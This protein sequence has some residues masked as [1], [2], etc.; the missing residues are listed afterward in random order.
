MHKQPYKVHVMKERWSYVMKCACC[1][2][3]RGSGGIKHENYLVREIQEVQEFH[4]KHCNNAMCFISIDYHAAEINNTWVEALT[5]D[6]TTSATWSTVSGAT[7]TSFMSNTKKYFVF[8]NCGMN[9]TAG[10]DHF[11]FRVTHG[12]TVITS[13]D[14]RGEVR[15]SDATEGYYVYNYWTVITA[16]GDDDI[17][18][19]FSSP[20]AGDTV[21]ARFVTMFAM[22]LSDDLIENTDWH[23]GE[24][25]TSVTLPSSYTDKAKVTFTPATA[26]NDWAVF[27]QCRN[28]PGTTSDSVFSAL[29]S[30]GTVTETTE[31]FEEE[32][33]DTS[34][35]RYVMAGMRVYESLGAISQT[36]AYQVYHED[37][38]AGAGDY[39]NSQVFALD[40]SLFKNHSSYW[41][42][43][44]STAWATSPVYN[45][46]VGTAD[47]SP[48]V[49]GDVWIL[50]GWSCINVA[51]TAYFG[52][53]LQFYEV[54]Q[55]Q[56]DSPSGQTANEYWTSCRDSTEQGPWYNQTRKNVPGGE[57]WRADMDA[58]GSAADNARARTMLLLTMELSAASAVPKY[59]VIVAG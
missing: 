36:F 30:A 5:E 29:R 53:R 3:K 14:Y 59:Q 23:Y 55:T 46:E 16:D 47:I 35:D 10:T 9:A 24:E 48:T 49:T 12:G 37:I 13:S 22:N 50:A 38:P 56:V 32:G 20:L 4:K 18:L 41:N 31:F 39:Y 51:N 27:F 7:I 45:E 11:A 2:G 34:T 6:T 15:L 54:G 26:G 33:K 28:N 57:S 1:G 43:A 17:D 44:N 8:I 58:W 40:L 21:Y 25:N 42:A 19:E 52:G